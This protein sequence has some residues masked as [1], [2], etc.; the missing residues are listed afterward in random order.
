MYNVA[1]RD[2]RLMLCCNVPTQ[3]EA[4]KWLQYY[5]DKYPPGAPYPNGLGFYPDFEFRVI[6]FH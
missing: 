4:E 5:N 2:D 6:S 1:D 3:T